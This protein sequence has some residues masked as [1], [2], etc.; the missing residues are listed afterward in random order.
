MA[1]DKKFLVTVL[2][3]DDKKFKAKLSKTQQNIVKFGV[4]AG[5]ASAAIATITKI[6][7]DYQDQTIKA[8]RAVGATA[9]E[10]STIKR[11]ADLANVSMDTLRGAM[12]KLTR[13][14]EQAKK[15][16]NE[17]GVSVRDSNGNLKSQTQLLGEIGDAMNKLNSPQ[18]KTRVAFTLFEEA[19]TRMI[20]MLSGGSKGMRELAEETQRMGLIVS[21]EAGKNAE[22][23]NDDL[24][25]TRDSI[26]GLTVSIG[27]S[28]I[29]FT[30]QSGIIEAVNTAIQGITSAWRNLDEDTKQFIVTAVATAGAITGITLALVAARAALKF[31]GKQAIKSMGPIGILLTALSALAAGIVKDWGSIKANVAPA[32]DTVSES[33]D[34]LRESLEKDLKIDNETIN[35]I[36]DY[37]DEIGKAWEETSI[38]G[39]VA[40]LTFKTIATFA[41]AVIGAIENIRQAVVS[42]KRTFSILGQSL[43]ALSK[44]NFKAAKLFFDATKTSVLLTNAEIGANTKKT[45]EEIEKI[46]STPLLVKLIEELKQ[47]REEMKRLDADG[48]NTGKDLEE[49]KDTTNELTEAWKKLNT[50]LERTPKNFKEIA[51]ASANVV[52]AGANAASIFTGAFSQSAS[53]IE[54]EIQRAASI[55]D[56]NN[57]VKLMRFQNAAEAELEAL[58]LVEDQK[59]KDIESSYDAQIKEIQKRELEQLGLLKFFK[60]ER[61][62]LSNEEFQRARA[63][64]EA[65]FQKTKE[66]QLAKWEFEKNLKVERAIDDLQRIEAKAIMDEDIALREEELEAQHREK[67]AALAEMF[68]NKE[69]ALTQNGRQQVQLI[70]SLKNKALEDAEKGRIDRVNA[71]QEEQNKR[72]AQLQKEQ[73]EDNWRAQVDAF[74]STKAAKKADT[75]VAGIAGAAQAFAALAPIPFV[76]PALGAIAAAM[77]MRNT[78]RSVQSIDSQEPIKPPELMLEEGGFVAGQQTHDR[79]GVNANLE[80]GELVVD[81]R[82]TADLL[83]LVDTITN[84]SKIEINIGAVHSADPLLDRST[85]RQFTDMVAR[86]LEI[87][88]IHS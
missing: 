8:A 67:M 79:G 86:E 84:G 74:N 62:L 34:R 64:A 78:R 20:N 77:I 43:E 83:S 45:Q 29:A 46:W 48:K 24:S 13:P 61:E 47:A 41:V 40:S 63:Q 5:A 19:G 16:L 85:V 14:S 81:R 7:A 26:K 31:I 59:I 11:G 39:T 54:Q 70:N 6:T 65:D 68:L 35:S 4:A 1:V 73:I 2:R 60:S 15:T 57:R 21:E 52:K 56:R 76:G 22:K 33:F 3:L 25:K 18:E 53:I 32:V 49:L 42:T 50:R 10:F 72:E 88:G 71:L 69:S 58:N 55:A 82:R 80:S 44:G 37:V 9:E 23:F 12:V 17:L 51:I 66:E 75:L 87:Q 36:T 28:V 27:E 38:L 30:N